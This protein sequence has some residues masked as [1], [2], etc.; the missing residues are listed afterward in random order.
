M[1]DEVVDKVV[2]KILEE[3]NTDSTVTER[4]PYTMSRNTSV[5]GQVSAA[6][7]HYKRLHQ[8]WS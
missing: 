6:M 5:S 8:K 7:T 3:V 4:L 2:D 1:A